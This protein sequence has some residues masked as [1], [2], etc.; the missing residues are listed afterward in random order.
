MRIL[1]LT[2]WFNPEPNF[3]GLLFAKEL[4]N[5]GHEVQVLTGFPNYPDGKVYDGYKIKL[6]QREI[7]DGISVFR[8][9]LYPSHDNKALNRIV[10]YISFAL[11]ASFLGFLG[12]KRPDVIYVYHPPA[13]IGLPALF[14]RLLYRVPFVYDIQD[15]WPDTLQ[16][17]GMI[18]NRVALWLVKKWCQFIYSQATKIVVLS[19]GFK[20]ILNR[21]GVP[22]DKIEVICNWCDEEYLHT[23]ARNEVLAKELGMADRFNIVFAGTMGKAQSLNSVLDAARLLRDKLPK[24]QFVFIGGGID[25]ER[26]KKIKDVQALMNVR[27][28]PRRPISEIGEILGLADVLLV[29]LKDDPLFKITIPGKTQA[30]MA[31]GRPIL[32]GV[33]GDAA[34]LVEKARAGLACMPEDPQDIAL[35][36][37]KMYNFPKEK[38]DQMGQNGKSFYKQELSLYVGTRRFEKIFQS[39]VK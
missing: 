26:L 37:E 9:P 20:D 15:L 4:S 33:R 38:L 11:S 2:Q 6:F 12:I 17:T 27:F 39:V 21:R 13:T 8:V 29:H 30:Y 36:V 28:L 25:V 3:K 1:L 34:I 32:M 35:A 23:V 24:I 16:A 31:A 5:L 18:N 14:L 7:M 22:M 10:N 19:P